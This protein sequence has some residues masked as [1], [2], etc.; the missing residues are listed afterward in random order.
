[1]YKLY[2]KENTMKALKKFAFLMAVITVFTSFGSLFTIT[3]S[4]ADETDYV[5]AIGSTKYTTLGDAVTA[6]LS[7]SQ[8]DNGAT[9]VTIE[10]LKD[11]TIASTS[12]ITFG[13]NGGNYFEITINGNGFSVTSTITSQATFTVW[14][15][16][17][18]LNNMTINST[19]NGGYGAIVSRDGN[20]STKTGKAEIVFNNVDFNIKVDY[21]VL[22]DFY[23]NNAGKV[24][25]TGTNT[26]ASNS[27]KAIFNTSSG[28]DFSASNTTV[29]AATLGLSTIPTG[30]TFIYE[31]VAKIGTTNY[32]TLEAAVGA[33]VASSKANSGATVTVELLKDTNIASAAGLTLSSKDDKTVYNVV[34][35][36]NGKTVTHKLTSTAVSGTFYVW[37][38]NATFN[39][40][41]INT[42]LNGSGAFG[43]IIS[44]GDGVTANVVLNNVNINTSA[45]AR[46]SGGSA[47]YLNSGTVTFKGTNNIVADY[48]VFGGGTMTSATAVGSVTTIQAP[49]GQFGLTTA[50]EGMTFVV[51]NAPFSDPVATVDGVGF[52]SFEAAVGAAVKASQADNGATKVTIELLDD[53][54]LTTNNGLILG[55]DGGKSF[56][57]VINGNDHAVT[58][59]LSN[60]SG[61]VSS[62]FYVWAGKLTL[63]NMTINAICSSGLAFGAIISRQARAATSNTG[64]NVI[65]NNVNINVNVIQKNASCAAVYANNYGL[66]TFTGTNT[67]R[68]NDVVFV[69]TGNSS[70]DTSASSTTV[71]AFTEKL[72]L[73]SIPQGITYVESIDPFEKGTAAIGT[74]VYDSIVEAFDNAKNGNVIT[75]LKDIDTDEM[76]EVTLNGK[77]ITFDGNGKTI[78]SSVN[79]SINVLHGTGTTRSALYIKDLTII[80]ADTTNNDVVLQT[81]TSVDAVVDNCKIIANHTSS[82]S[83]GALVVQPGGSAKI[84]GGSEIHGGNGLAIRPNGSGA[85]LTI[86]NAKI[87][88]DFYGISAYTSGVEVN[89]EAGAEITTAEP[90]FHVN[91][92]ADTI[93]NIT[94]G[95][96]TTNATDKA[97]ITFSN[98]N[99]KVNYF[100]GSFEGGNAIYTNAVIPSKSISYPEN[101]TSMTRLPVMTDGASIRLATEASGIRFRTTFSKSFLDYANALAE[102]IGAEISYGTLIT[103][104][105]YL[106]FTSGVFSKEALDACTD[107]SGAK[108]VDVKATN[109]LTV[110]DDGSITVNASIVNIKTSNYRYAFAAT[111]Y[112]C[113]TVNGTTFYVYTDYS[114]ENNARSIYD[115]TRVAYADVSATQNDVYKYPV[116]KYLVKRV[117]GTYTYEEGNAFSRF[118]ETQIKILDNYYNSIANYEYTPSINELS[119]VMKPI[120][121]GNTVKNETVFFIDYGDEKTL[122]YPID[123]VIS[124][125]SYDGSTVY[126]EGVD[127]SIVNGKIKILNGSSIPCI[128]SAK[129]YNVSE[130]MLKT[131]YNGQNVNTYW[132]EGKI[133]TNY[134]VNISY[135]HTSQWTGYEQESESD[136]YADFI[137]K[138]MD[139]EDVT[140]FFYGD[141]I[142]KGANASWLMGYAPYQYNYAILFTHALADLFDY[143]VTYVETGAYGS[144]IP[145]S[146]YVAGTRGTI[147]YVNSAVGGWKSA[148]GVSNYDTHVKPFINAYGCDLFVCAFGMNDTSVAVSTTKANVKAI[149]DKV[150]AAVSDT[151]VMLVSTMVPNPDA[152]NGIYGNQKD[153][154]PALL[155]LAASYQSTG[156]NCA[157]ACMNSMSKSVLTRKKF[158]DYTGNNVNHP[159]DF[160][161]GIYAQTLLQTLIG[162]ENLK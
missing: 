124:V 33:A 13:S 114:E 95:K 98:A 135:T 55:T 28:L 39:N 128:T 54:T 18:T 132:G 32:N 19:C 103:P 151:S 106:E 136:I 118:D 154:E 84:M 108:Y 146:N 44:R 111:G 133:M 31:A 1:M 79:K 25:F 72:G 20:T 101:E 29:K 16:K 61:D 160:F 117:N 99:A 71:I 11:L 139:G 10:L 12:G 142:T 122:L 138:L 130:T 58:G 50:P 4:A 143:T 94:G 60:T 152:T 109:G 59:T 119:D 158:V 131:E 8:A 27:T 21:Q 125:T 83:L 149:V 148:D 51:N 40:M 47:I 87:T 147:T 88:S 92:D 45:T 57:V 81:G 67:I 90:L 48:Q 30:L 68:T 153:Q 70:L 82:T 34:I 85:K 107:I 65:L 56:D 5:A 156:K 150:Y 3:G 14:M 75:L 73:N 6:A 86:G 38:G 129:Y 63:N 17:L 42:T 157:V 155:E 93:V 144:K 126:R 53:V 49:D 134:Q 115:I 102:A 104:A 145:T 91:A 100:G 9:K 23:I 76:I 41:T 137:Q 7:T 22:N 37:N 80:S 69:F 66:I 120:F 74:T 141:S 123:S 52:S 110:N 159:N 162:Y 140:I 62:I 78:T 116:T 43:P 121:D 24:T 89:I 112:I 113:F 77:S 36:G 127:Y 46:H 15:G 2:I 96:I 26:I 35:N 64:E 105:K 97:V 161:I